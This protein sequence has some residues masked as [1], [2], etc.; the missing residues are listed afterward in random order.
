MCLV[1]CLGA[2]LNVP[3]PGVDSY[4]GAS[5]SSWESSEESVSLAL[6]GYL[7]SVHGGQEFSF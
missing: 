5:E 7:V 3:Y 6:F 2:T 1:F 4:E